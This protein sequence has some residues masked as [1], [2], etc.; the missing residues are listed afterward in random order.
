MVA[1]KP[2]A[3]FRSFEQ[4]KADMFPRLTEQD[5]KRSSKWSSKQIGACMADDAIEALLRERQQADA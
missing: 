4:F 1:K 5:R 3:L 2:T